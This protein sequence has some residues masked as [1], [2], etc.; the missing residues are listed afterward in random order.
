MASGTGP[1]L[2]PAQHRSR[3]RPDSTGFAGA[4]YQEQATLAREA[5]DLLED[6]PTERRSIIEEGAAF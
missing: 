5:L 6:G 4:T 3:H 1:R 2:I